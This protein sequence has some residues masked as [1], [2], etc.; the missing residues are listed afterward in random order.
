M[1]FNLMAFGLGSHGDA[2]LVPNSTISDHP[3]IPA[4]SNAIQF[5][6]CG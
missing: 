5:P 2:T 4:G 6:K 3:G 1:R